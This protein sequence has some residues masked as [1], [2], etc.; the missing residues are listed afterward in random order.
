MSN[1]KKDLFAGLFFMGVAVLYLIGTF[2]IPSYSV[3]GVFSFDSTVIPRVLSALTFIFGLGQA[4]SGHGRWKEAN[5]KGQGEDGTKARVGT[6]P[7]AKE[8]FTN[9]E[10]IN[11]KSICFT[12]LFLGGYI[13]FLDRIGFILMTSIYL[14][15][16]MLLLTQSGARK[17]MALTIVPLSVVFSAS[18]Y[19][20]FVNV[21]A[22]ILPAGILK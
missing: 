7:A 19:F 12:I 5:S 15:T 11:K 2:S 13:V 17:K 20:L 1:F 18:V 3:F 14:I 6:E 10:K 22:L 8:D 4:L 9:G 21:F 16:Q